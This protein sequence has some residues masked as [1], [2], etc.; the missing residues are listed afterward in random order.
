MTVDNLIIIKGGAYNDIKKALRQWIDLYS[1]DLQDDLTFQ[2]FKN[3]R[4][5]HIIQA[6]K[7]LNN[8]RFYYLINYLN[9]PEGIEYKI[10]IEGFTT[11][12]DD[13]K[14]KSKSLL[15][16][17]SPTDQEYDNV[18]VT[19][20]ENENYKVDFGGRITETAE[21]RNFKLPSDL[22]FELPET[23]AVEK[24]H[25]FETESG[26]INNNLNKR[27]KIISAIIISAFALTY[28][29]FKADENFLKINFVIAFVVWGWLTVDYKILQVDKLYFGSVALGLT[30]LLFGYL[31]KKE[32]TNEENISLVL[33]GTSMP[34]FFLI[35]QRPARFV[36]KRIM[37]REPKVD[38]PAP[39]FAD[40]VYIFILWTT[41]IL[42]PAS[43]YN[44]L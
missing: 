33:S 37:K 41:T 13:N 39:S 42:I 11:G 9:Y 8:E 32:L 10:D 2:L 5:K 27:F 1:K 18:F 31:L 25:D 35:I 23:L 16:Y 6:D 14:L 17:I 3:G 22:T 21:R 36:F 19:T 24:R 15:V 28:L 34:I 44:A 43:Y 12:K 30:I 38:R 7:R 40:F 20:S 4:G 29:I 26:T